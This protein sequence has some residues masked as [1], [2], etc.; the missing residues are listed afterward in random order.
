MQGMPRCSCI[1]RISWYSSCLPRNEWAKGMKE[2]GMLE[3][4]LYNF[5]EWSSELR[6]TVYGTQCNGGRVIRG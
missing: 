3:L 5:P 1:W 2:T 6:G 4:V